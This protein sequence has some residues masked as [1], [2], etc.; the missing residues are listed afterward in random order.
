[1]KPIPPI[2]V[3]E[4][5]SGIGGLHQG[6]LL[7]LPHLPPS[8][9]SRPVEV[10]PFDINP[11]ANTIYHLNHGIHPST[12]DI[13]NLTSRDLEELD[14]R[15]LWLLS[16]PCQPYTRNGVRKG[17]MDGRAKSFCGML[18]SV[19]G[20]KEDLRPLRILVENVLGFESSD[21][22]QKLTETLTAC[23]YTYQGFVLNPLDLG[24]PNSRPRF[25][26]LAK[27]PSLKFAEPDATSSITNPASTL[28][29]ALK[30]H[31]HSDAF[32]SP[33]DFFHFLN[34]GTG[35]PAR[36]PIEA[37][38]EEG[39]DDAL[40]VD[41]EM[42][43][44]GGKMLDVVT[45]GDNR[46]CCF[47]K[48][49]GSYARGTGSV[50][51]MA[52]DEE[53]LK[54]A[55]KVKGCEE[56]GKVAEVD[57]NSGEG[58]GR[59]GE[60]GAEV[61]DEE[62]DRT[63]EE[64]INIL[65]PPEPTTSPKAATSFALASVYVH[66]NHLRI[67]HR[68]ET[69]AHLEILSKTPT[70]SF[71]A[72]TSTGRPKKP[73]AKSKRALDV[74]QGEWWKKAGECPLA[75]LKLRF[76]SVSE[77]AKLMGWPDGVCVGTD[78]E[79]G[80]VGR[81]GMWKLLGN[82]LNTKIVT[83]DVQS[84]YPQQDLL[85]HFIADLKSAQ[86]VDQI[87]SIMGNIDTTAHY[88]LHFDISDYSDGNP[89]LFNLMMVNPL[90]IVEI[91]EKA[92]LHVQEELAQ[93]HSLREVLTI[94][95]NIHVRFMGGQDIGKLATWGVPRSGD[96][97]RL[98]RFKGTVIRTGS[99]KMIQTAKIFRCTKCNGRF[100]VAFDRS[101]YNAF[102]KPTRCKGFPDQSP[103][104]GKK[105]VEIN[106][107]PGSVPTFCKDYQEI[108]VQELITKL[109]FGTIPRSITVILED[110]ITDLCKAG[111]DVTIM[112]VSLLRYKPLVETKRV[113]SEVAMLANSIEVNND[114][115]GAGI[116][117]EELKAEFKQHWEQHSGTP[118]AG[119]DV[120]LKS[121]C[122]TVIG[123]S[124]VK[125]AVMLVLVGGVAKYDVTGLKIRGDSHLLLVGDPGTGKSQF[126]R[127]A[128]LLSTR[129]ILTTGIGSTSAGLTV[130]AV[131]DSGEWQLEAGALVLADRGICCID[132]F[133]GIRENDKTAIHEAMEQQTISVAKAGLVC[134]LNTRCSILAAS[135]PK[136]KYD[137]S[138]NLE[139][140]IG[141]GSPLL[142][143]FDL[144]LILLDTQND[145]W[146]RKVSSFILDLPSEDESETVD[147][148]KSTDTFKPWDFVKL[149]AYIKYVKAN[150]DPEL[151]D[152]AS[153]ILQRYYQLQRNSDIRNVARTTVRLLE[154][155]IRLTQAH[156]RLMCK[157]VADGH[158]AVVAVL[159]MELSM[160]ASGLATGDSPL[161]APFPDE[162]DIFFGHQENDLLRKMGLEGLL[163]NSNKRRTDS[164]NGEHD[165]F[166]DGEDEG[167]DYDRYGGFMGRGRRRAR[168]NEDGHGDGEGDDDEEENEFTSGTFAIANPNAINTVIAELAKEEPPVDQPSPAT[169]LQT[170]DHLASVADDASRVQ[171]YAKLEGRDLSYFVTKLQVVIG[172]KA[173][174]ADV[175][176]DLGI[177]KSISRQHARI[178]FNFFSELFELVVLGKN[179][180]VINNRYVPINS[181]PIPLTHN[182]HIKIGEHEMTFL[183]PQ[184]DSVTE[185]GAT[186]PNNGRSYPLKHENPEDSNSDQYSGSARPR[187]KAKTG[188]AQASP[189]DDGEGRDRPNVSYATMIYQ[190]ILSSG[191]QKKMTLNGI[192]KWISENYPFYQMSKPGWQNSIRQ[193]VS[194]NF[195]RQQE[196]I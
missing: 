164:P 74:A 41:E 147:T 143:R 186:T 123:M 56:C 2:R 80:G 28:F 141:L 145:D 52:G 104:N 196:W 44:K 126:L 48:S 134:K 100:S 24:I 113:E 63:D 124:I 23:S 6:L 90:G 85:D 120:I 43:W 140:N 171:A 7:A 159:M 174:Q 185:S 81:E 87:I 115:G 125:L 131:K 118:M 68:N 82:S 71:Y 169:T 167:N 103:C 111:D 92:T 46:S 156:A 29:E 42:L 54:A 119:R 12:I 38:L 195:F 102:P 72:Y 70:S 117:T 142:S 25:F 67:H 89:F 77:V 135:N 32:G 51:K 138:L 88:S 192:Y 148:Q 97:G 179:G 116:L 15:D 79:F 37:F 45:G 93:T 190:A 20:M 49:Y 182:T 122:P 106:Y 121:F 188:M 105:F 181:P 40:L 11:H 168:G 170:P 149:Q 110:D 10:Q 4:F 33:D 155:L 61:E 133:G 47:T 21:T 146:D 78:G 162:P 150:C 17:S 177:S 13:T 27:H 194:L 58:D 95:P 75:A 132:E 191:D 35:K 55:E 101:L 178:Q 73:S 30:T 84:E 98:F 8:F 157:N 3:A 107:E 127:Y 129:S 109:S 163:G 60:M 144:I 36:K 160:N 166:G 193:Y 154:S 99:R 137:F 152:D 18:E 34:E 69:R 9:S 184:P 96:V 83:M 165:D 172:R 31:S 180:V 62:E 139:V 53:I 176:I 39:V 65:E 57:V 16:P 189:T 130:S 76:F 66:Y 161:H 86:Y 1:M 183:L 22:F 173:A 91:L 108:K 112:G 94:K 14:A 19:E 136:G 158:D 50:L 64:Q 151:S 175:D 59:N 153:T 5:Y 128:S 187:K 26:L 114:Q